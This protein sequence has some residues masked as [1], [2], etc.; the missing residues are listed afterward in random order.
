MF[1][2]HFA[3]GFAAKRAAPRTSLGLLMA[4]PLLLDLIWPVLVLAGLERVE[5]DPGNTAFTP[6]AFVSYPISHSLLTVAGW[7]LLAS[8]VYWTATR[9][10]AGAIVLGLAVIS[11]WFMDLVVHKPDLPL[12][13]GS[14]AHAGFGLWNHVAGTMVTEGLIFA[15]GVWFYV[16]GTRAKDRTGKIALWAFI[17]LLLVL[18]V[19]NVV[20]PPPPSSRVVAFVGLLGALF[21]VWAAWF[22]RHRS[23]GQA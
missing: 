3:V 15:A 17:V 12:F 5:I 14:D 20:G 18:Y 23:I 10:R 11:H 9:Y 8:A 6:L 2:G 13:P 21:P 19:A 16:T 4:A 1:I 22:D 7:G